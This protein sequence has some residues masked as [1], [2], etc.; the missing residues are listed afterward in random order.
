MVFIFVFLLPEVEEEQEPEPEQQEEEE[1][2]A[3]EDGGGKVL[4]KLFPLRM[5]ENFSQS[6][7]MLSKS[8]PST[9]IHKC[10]G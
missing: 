9:L 2:Q 3:E 6:P 7:E 4:E 1:E 5:D 10:C 8:W